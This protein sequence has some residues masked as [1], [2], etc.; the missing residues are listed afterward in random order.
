[1][2]GVR[3][4]VVRLRVAVAG[5]RGS[6]SV[7]AAFVIAVVLCVAVGV[8]M[9][10][11]AVVA[12]HAARAVADLAAVSGAQALRDGADGCVEAG[13]VGTANGADWLGCRVDGQDV[14]VCARLRVDVGVFGGREASAAALAGPG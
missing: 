5:D 4:L 14:V 13:R 7:L 12:A 3:V 6:M 8:L 2:S 9:V 10:A 1:M 11:R